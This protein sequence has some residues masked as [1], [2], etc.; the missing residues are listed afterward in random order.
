MLSN[1]VGLAHATPLPTPPEARHEDYH[2]ERTAREILA[3]LRDEQT[4]DK[5][6]GLLGAYETI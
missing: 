6:L 5:R 3:A 1:E 4:E 2:C